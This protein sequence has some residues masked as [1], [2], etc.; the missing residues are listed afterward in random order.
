MLNG[1]PA[2]RVVGLLAV[3]LWLTIA[4]LAEAQHQ[5]QTRVAPTNDLPN[6][7]VRVHP[8]G[9]LPNPYEPGAYDAR[10]SF[11]GADEGPD[12]N[13]YLLSRC[14][15]N[16]C[17]GRSESALLKLDPDGQLLLSWGS[18]MF[19]FPHGL[20]LDD[21]GNVWVA[22][23][24][25][26]RVVKFDADGNLLL[27]I[28][29]R[30][31]AGDPPR[32]NE[33]TDVVVAATGE[34]FITEGHSFVAGA[35]RVTKYAADGSFLMSWGQ[36]GSAPGEF[37]VPHTIALDSQGRLFVGDRGNNRIQIF[38]QQG[39]FLDVWYQ[40]GR[41]SGIAIGADDR[42]YVADSESF[43]TDNP[44]W[45][46]GIRVGSAQDGSVEY[47]IEDLE[48]YAIEHSG[49]EGVGVDLAGNVYGAVVRR[50]MLERHE[51]NGTASALPGGGSL[52]LGHVAY[53]F[54]GAPDGMGLA[55]TASA[56]VGAA[57]LH[58]N[59][60]A[61][62]LSDFAAMRR[63]GAHV[64]HLLDPADGASGP[65]LGF[66]VIPAVE[67]LVEHLERAAAESGA[68]DNLETH[69]GHVTQIA[70]GMLT[71]AREAVDIASQLRDAVSIR[72]A[73]PLV[74]RLQALTYQIAEG[75]DEDRDGRLSFDGEAGM[76]QLEAHLYLLL[77]GESLPRELR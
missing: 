61:G 24:R 54:P 32:L 45:K 38:D 18:G 46:K 17:T 35:N 12:G 77:E 44:G 27:T 29:D 1:K 22:D 48:P 58:A 37:N 23:Q 2:V 49:A 71:H 68:S 34:V 70:D 55:A 6:P 63:H 66:G 41:P 13:I 11:I 39:T 56:E 43:G 25:G 14:L 33:P 72:R 8:W 62:D 3:V 7:Y 73:A 57:V 15:Q 50:R 40:F 21:E 42:I 64:L 9:E 47:L 5:D 74:G 30:G 19:D 52:H 20:D 69:T 67:A 16:S 10:A 65:G 26:H 75:F 36:T 4:G 53:V 28:G 76:Q 51:P 60:A 59:F 31:T